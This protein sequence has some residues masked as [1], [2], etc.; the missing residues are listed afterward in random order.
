M[1]LRP[2]ILTRNLLPLHIAAVPAE[3]PQCHRHGPGLPGLNRR[4]HFHFGDVYHL[5]AL[6]LKDR[7]KVGTRTNALQDRV[8]T[9]SDPL[10]RK[11]NHSLTGN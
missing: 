3:S 11:V 4:H 9:T 8:M 10:S 2:T 6:A 5:P 7:P 1:L